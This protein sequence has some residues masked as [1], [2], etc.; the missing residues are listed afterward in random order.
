ME[1]VRNEVAQE[2]LS[3]ITAAPQDP[4]LPT[5]QAVG[6]A[7]N[8]ARQPRW[9]VSYLCSLCSPFHPH[10]LHHNAM[11]IEEGLHPVYQDMIKFLMLRRSWRYSDA[12][13]AAK[14]RSDVC[15]RAVKDAAAAAEARRVAR[16]V[17]R[18]QG[19]AER[20]LT[21]QQRMDAIYDAGQAATLTSRLAPIYAAMEAARVARHTAS[22]SASTEPSTTEEVDEETEAATTERHAAELAGEEPEDA[23]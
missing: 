12:V 17:A 14:T 1:R 13:R 10:V 15:D 5:T 3:S 16:Y 21:D 8:N 9:A 20:R 11:A 22:E 2:I 18:D 7:D 6:D 19:L 4:V 23:S